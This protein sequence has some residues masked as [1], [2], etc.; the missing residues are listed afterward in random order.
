MGPYLLVRGIYNM[1][2]CLVG[3]CLWFLAVDLVYVL[4]PQIG[5]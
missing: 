3:A 1:G 4:G 2:P 5:T